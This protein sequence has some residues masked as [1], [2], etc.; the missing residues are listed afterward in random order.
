MIIDKKFITPI[1]ANTITYQDRF[2]STNRFWEMNPSLWIE[3]NGN[4]TLLLRTVNY[5]TYQNKTFQ[6]YS[7]I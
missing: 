3:Q 2:G 7:K 4:F 5:L 6:V 1:F